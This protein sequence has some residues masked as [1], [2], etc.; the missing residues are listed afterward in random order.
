MTAL[1]WTA[2][3]MTVG[4]AIL[5]ATLGLCRPFERTYLSFA[6]IMA[7]LALFL[8]F[9]WEFY[10]ATTSAAAVMATRRQVTVVVG[11]LACMLVFV[12][13][14]TKVRI[15]R[16]LMAVFW[17]L[18]A[19]LF[20]ANLLAPYG[21]WY[22]ALPELVRSQF[23][24]EPYN[25]VIAR[26]MGAPQYAFTLYFTSL[27]VVSMVCAVKVYRR[28]ERQ[29]GLT[30]A[31]ALGVILVHSL[32]DVVRDSIGASWP[33][34]AEFGVVTWA[35]IMSV[36]LAR[37]F[38]TQAQTL[39]HAIMHVEAQAARLES[40]LSSLRALEQNMDAPLHT[41]EAGLATLSATTA[42]DDGQL[43][44]MRRAV[45]RLRDVANSMPER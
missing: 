3:G 2:I 26:P 15:P 28:G 18:L 20:I 12:P 8:F 1:L 17:A 38:R 44:R 21:L 35:L 37:D 27:L 24:G 42:S 32:V 33:Y 11:F 43:P 10:R 4:A 39:G 22:S 19:V 23:R 7:L 34:V 36:Q 14:Y 5:H 9:Q 6:C 41:L 30:F 25:T 45:T 40:I 31:V 29:R 13:S 16:P